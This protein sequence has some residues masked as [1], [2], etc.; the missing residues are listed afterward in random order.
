MADRRDARRVEVSTLMQCCIDLKPTRK[1]NEV[2]INRKMDVTNLVSFIEKEKKEGKHYT[3]FHAFL[4]A[5]ARTIYHRPKLN[6]FISNRHMYEHNEILLS[7]VAKMTLDDK[8]EELMLV[9]PIDENDTIETIADKTAEK[10][11]KLRS[12]SVEKKG[13]NNA[14]DTLGKMPNII[15]VPIFAILKTLAKFGKLPSSLTDNNIYF[16]SMIIS[17]LG[18]IGCGAIYHNLA[19]FGSCSS[20]TTI[21]EINDEVVVNEKGKQEIR[22]MCEFGITLDERIGDG[23]YFA[24]C[25][26]LIEK[27]L[28]DPESLYEPISKLPE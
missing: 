9:V 19:D 18:S 17:N 20:L 8:S 21:G 22:K 28:D 24:R 11:N 3:Y 12:A 6:R 23:F 10:V 4:A 1:E 14:A 5:I 25:V 27:I 16:S 13:A 15:R 7:F 26:D 2:Y